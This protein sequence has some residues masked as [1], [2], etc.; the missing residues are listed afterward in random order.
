MEKWEDLFAGKLFI[1]D[2][3]ESLHT[4]VNG[5]EVDLGRY[6]VFSP[7]KGHPGHQAIEVGSDVKLLAQK[8]GITEE[9]ICVLASREEVK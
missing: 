2:I 3:G 6:A 1:T 7:N 4:V 9:R 8:Y 5:K